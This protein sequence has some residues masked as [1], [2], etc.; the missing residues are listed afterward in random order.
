MV[1]VGGQRIAAHSWDH[2]AQ[3]EYGNS[4]TCQDRVWE[5]FWVSLIWFINYITS[6]FGGH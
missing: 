6:C 1:L 4:G 5:M 2:Y 3:K